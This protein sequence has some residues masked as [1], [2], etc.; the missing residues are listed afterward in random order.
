MIKLALASILILL[1]PEP[2]GI[3]DEGMTRAIEKQ[4]AIRER[5][6]GIQIEVRL[7][8]RALQRGRD[9]AEAGLGCSAR[10]CVDTAVHDR[11]PGQ[12]GLDRS[13]DPHAGAVVRVQMN[14]KVR[15]LTE[16]RNQQR[17]RSRL[18]QPS[19]VLDG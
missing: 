1:A 4:R 17:G 15:R 8:F 13:S 5:L 18:E 11:S 16:C 3:P 10:Q 9:G 12:G 6:D 7:P 14:G 19:H 2:L